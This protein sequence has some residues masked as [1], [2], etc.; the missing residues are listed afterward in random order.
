LGFRRRWSRRSRWN[1]LRPPPIR[2]AGL[3]LDAQGRS[4]SYFRSGR[5]SLISTGFSAWFHEFV[6]SR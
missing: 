2:P 4:E 1:P 3:F 5:L 6:R